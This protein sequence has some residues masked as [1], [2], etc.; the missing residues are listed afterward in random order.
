MSLS[1]SQKRELRSWLSAN[2]V[3][4][5]ERVLGNPVDAEAAWRDYQAERDNAVSPTPTAS[6]GPPE[7]SSRVLRRGRGKGRGPVAVPYTMRLAPDLRAS[8]D[9]RAKLEARPSSE[10]VRLALQAYLATPFRH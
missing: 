7:P 6:A 10:V 3:Q 4:F 1:K 8:L 9:E 5:P 2:G